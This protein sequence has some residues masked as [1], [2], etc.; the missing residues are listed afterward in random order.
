MDKTEQAMRILAVFLKS[1]PGGEI[2]IHRDELDKL[3]P[4]TKIECFQDGPLVVVRVSTVR[5]KSE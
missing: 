3:D 5:S 1:K 2:R 4:K